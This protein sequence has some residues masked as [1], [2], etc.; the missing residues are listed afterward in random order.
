MDIYD[1]F[2]AVRKET[3]IE[4]RE[5]AARFDISGSHLSTLMTGRRAPSFALAQH[6]EKITEGKVTMMEMMQYAQERQRKEGIF[7][8][9]KRSPPRKG[10]NKRAENPT[11]T[12]PAVVEFAA[13]QVKVRRGTMKKRAL[14]ETQLEL[15]L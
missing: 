14:K 7:R 1:Y 5:M 8:A 12:K 11:E 10:N 2:Y 13:E 3:G 4:H 9:Y 15:A 6:I